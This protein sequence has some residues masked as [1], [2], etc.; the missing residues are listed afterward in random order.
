MSDWTQFLPQAEQWAR[1]QVPLHGTPHLKRKKKI[2]LAR[3]PKLHIAHTHNRLIAA[4]RHPEPAIVSK[5][6]PFR[7][8]RRGA[9]RTV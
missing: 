7:R 9:Y 4:G 5:R 3:T 2:R 8:T 6:N 1:Q